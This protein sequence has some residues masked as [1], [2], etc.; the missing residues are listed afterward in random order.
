MAVFPSASSR[1]LAVQVRSFGANRTGTLRIQAPAGWTVQP[2]HRDFSL[3][4]DGEEAALSF[5]VAP[6]SSA[7]SGVLKAVATVEGQ[8]IATN[9]LTIDYPHIPARTAFLPSEARLVRADVQVL[10]RR[11]GYVMGAGDEVPEALRQMGCAVTLLEEADLTRGDLSGF[12]AIVTGVRA[13]NT[14]ADLRASHAR[15][16]EYVRAG[17]TMV[18][19]YNVLEG[20]FMGG[21]PTQLDRI[22]PL[23]LKIGRERVSVED[24]PVELLQPDHD[25]LRRP[26]RITGNDWEGWVQERG[27]Y[28]PAQWDPGYTALV[29][30][31][32]PQE[33]PVR[34]GI[35]YAR[36]GKGVYV[37]TSLSWFRQLP[38][39]VPG[40]WRIF[41]NLISAGKAQ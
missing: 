19:Q 9:V 41:A 33:K 17:G 3:A 14:R 26:N 38:A 10:A 25:L 16:M 1:T 35:L 24:A 39:G 30:M 29:S 36:H 23:P 22:G 34:G 37:F 5:N 18:V 31:S 21:D 15:L 8:Q 11:V 13:F 20:G 7:A 28:F 2:A 6:P 4:L 12:G 40:A 27:L 32:D